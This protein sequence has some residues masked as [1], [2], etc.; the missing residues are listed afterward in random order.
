MNTT[1]ILKSVVLF[2]L[3]FLATPSLPAVEPSVAYYPYHRKLRARVDVSM[4]PESSAVTG[5]NVVLTLKGSDKSITKGRIARLKNGIGETVLNTPDLKNGIYSV[6][7]ALAGGPQKLQQPF[8][9]EFERK[10]WPW[11]HNDIGKS[12]LI[13]PP[14]TPLQVT[15]AGNGKTQVSSVLRKH[16][17][18]GFGLW[19]QVKSRDIDILAGP[20]RLVAG[21]QGAPV[22]W[23]YQPLKLAEQS[24]DR[25]IVNSSFSGGPISAKATSEFDYDGMMKVT[26]R[27]H[28]ATDSTAVD[29][30]DLVIPLKQDV[31]ELMHIIGPSIRANPVGF[32]PS[33]TGV[34]WNS[35]DQ[36]EIWHQPSAPS[37]RYN[38]IHGTFV[39]YVWLGGPE[40]GVCWFADTDRDWSLDDDRAALEIARSEGAVTLKVR[41]FNKP[42]VLDRPRTIVFGLLATPVKPMPRPENGKTWRSWSFHIRYPNTRRIAFVCPCLTWGAEEGDVDVYPRNRD[43]TIFDKFGEARETGTSTVPQDWMNTWLDG[44]ANQLRRDEYH[45]YVTSGFAAMASAMPGVDK[46]ILYTNA[47]GAEDSTCEESLNYN[48]RPLNK[49]EW[50][51]PKTSLQDFALYYFKEMMDRGSID[52]LYLD[53]VYAAPNLDTISADAYV[54]EDGKL[55]PSMGIFSTRDY[56]KRIA[57]MYYEV[58]KMPYTWVHMTNGNLIPAFSFAQIALDLEWKFDDKTDF[59][60]RF[61]RDMLL[62]QSLGLQAGLIPSVIDGV[63]ESAAERERLNRTEFG[64]ITVHEIKLGE[65]RVNAD[66]LAKAYTTLFGFGYGLEDCRVYRYWEPGQ[67]VISSLEDVKALVLARPSTEHPGKSKCLIIVSDF[68]NGGDVGMTVN[69]KTIGLRAGYTATDAETGASLPLAGNKVTFS[70]ARHDFRMIALE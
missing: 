48:P 16:T 31:A 47:R 21:V 17:M 60:D 36:Q 54:R 40:R 43:L 70:I 42:T 35:K 34:V 6:R 9:A 1:P 33:G 19:D 29:Y 5:A 44:Y 38:M 49:N 68:G 10:V 66:E 41:L 69:A 57:T 53:N 28:P 65:T 7:F 58:G 55:Q 61:G 50:D 25:V 3:L 26:L 37:T 13:I 14:F 2:S 64:A 63:P 59:Q 67:P 23:N 18:N 20:V 4:H 39:P 45:S 46:V 56:I 22:K 27:I 11:E 30:L 62:A 15:A 12:R 52:G 32:V 8:H 24:D 51:E